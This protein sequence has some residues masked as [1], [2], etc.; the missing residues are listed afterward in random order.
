MY[1]LNSDIYE[2]KNLALDKISMIDKNQIEIYEKVK[3]I[4]KN[5]KE[6]SSTSRLQ[7]LGEKLLASK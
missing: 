1:N 5:S 4:L 7:V 6:E 2:F 3:T